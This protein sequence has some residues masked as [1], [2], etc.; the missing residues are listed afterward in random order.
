MKDLPREHLIALDKAHVWHPY[1]AMD[2]YIAETNPLVVTR[3]S[4]CR[5]FDADGR[6]YIDGNASWWCCALG[7]NH[8]RLVRALAAQAERFSHVALAGITHEPAVALA[9]RLVGVA[10]AGLE[11]VFFSD[12]GSTSV[13]VAL[14]MSLQ[15]W[16]QN[17]RPERTRF[18]AFEGAYH[19]DTL[20]TTGLGGVELFRRPFA[21]VIMDCL[22][23]PAAS[24]G[25]ERAFL[26]LEA[27]LEQSSDQIAAVVLEPMVQGAAGMRMYDAEFLRRARALTTK[28]DV[29]L[30]LD[31]VFTGYGRT[32][33]MW[34]CAHAGIAPDLLCTSKGF[35]GGM[36]PM[37]AT[38]A[39]RRIFEGFFG[40]AE[41]SFFY[42]HTFTGNPLGAA[43]ALEVLRVYE[44]ECVLERAAAK[45]ERI[46]AAFAGLAQ[47]PGVLTTRSL[48]MIGALELEGRKGYLERGGLRVYHEALRR[49]AYL[50]PM[51]NVVYITPAV[52]IGD[53]DLDELLGILTESVRV[54][55]TSS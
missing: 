50:R 42:G 33:P 47:L 40:G 11:H 41:R 20:G 37:A 6:A 16:S 43:V 3:A 2:E 32:G 8:P 38:L 5:L 4:G 49:G 18:V 48:G 45:A 15:Y 12:D 44:E 27:L 13:E 51:G 10:P 17:G 28:H 54:V 14:K 26:A 9:K 36:L 25:Y 23:V 39:T 21:S 19:G 1:T 30:V 46:R 34:A 22:R 52:N 55:T 53:A 35:T 7:H 31:E 24:D 29:F